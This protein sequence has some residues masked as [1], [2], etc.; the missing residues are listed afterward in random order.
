MEAASP[1]WADPSI[2]DGLWHAYIDEAGEAG[3]QSFRPRAPIPKNHHFSSR[4]FIVAASLVKP[5]IEGAL[6]ERW[7]RIC[8]QAHVPKD[9]QAHFVD[10]SWKNRLVLMEGILRMPITLFSTVMLKP[11][12][13]HEE[14]PETG[15]LFY[16]ATVERV[17][18]SVVAHLPEDAKLR[19]HIA[20]W[21]MLTADQYHEN[22]ARMRADPL[23]PVDWARVAPGL[24]LRAPG[25]S[26]LLQIADSV[27]GALFA[28]FSADRYGHSEVGMLAVIFRRFGR[29]DVLSQ[30]LGYGLC[31]YP[32]TD[33]AK[34]EEHPWTDVLFKSRAWR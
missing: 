33:E 18:A 6:A 20:P 2:E 19:L 15:S 17:V 11:H 22:F 28:A 21:S 32:E 3:F 14:R 1:Q 31:I 24:D 13:P 12:I 5:G 30:P 9:E 26:S 34:A 23:S 16:F 7:K 29:P 8:N 27:A 25:K 10:V 4:T